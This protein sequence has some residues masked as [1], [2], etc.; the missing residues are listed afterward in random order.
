MYFINANSDNKPG[1]IDT[2]GK[3]IIEDP[4]SATEFDDVSE[5]E[6]YSGCWGKA[7]VN[8]YAFNVK[9]KGIACGL[10]NLLKLEDGDRLA[11]ADSATNDFADDLDDLL[12][13]NSVAG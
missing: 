1:I 3:K 6:F 8:F 5:E 2:K 7:S 11:G 13:Q 9:N 4:E 12:D 10:N